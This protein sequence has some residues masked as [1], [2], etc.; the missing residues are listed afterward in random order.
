M[1]AS[2]LQESWGHRPAPEGLRL[3]FTDTHVWL[4]EHSMLLPIFSSSSTADVHSVHHMQP[5][6]SSLHHYILT[7]PVVSADGLAL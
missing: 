6:L 4:D 1:T 5:Q 3:Q 7:A 2:W